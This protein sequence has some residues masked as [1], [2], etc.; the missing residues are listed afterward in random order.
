MNG[1]TPY[2]GRPDATGA[3]QRADADVPDLSADE[4][5]DLR[6][7]LDTVAAR[8][9]E[10]LPDEYVVGAQIVAGTD[11]PEGTIAVQPPVG[12]AVSAG[13]TP[14]A[15]ELVDGIPDE[16]RDEVAHQLAATAALQV[17]RAVE[18]AVAPVAQ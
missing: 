5:R 3:G 12:P 8:T 2:A 4:R 14:D 13:F 7:G 15:E 17:K 6:A 1:N 10:F 11:G 18:D 9:R 16:D